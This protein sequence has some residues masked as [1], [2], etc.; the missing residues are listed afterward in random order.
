MLDNARQRDHCDLSSTTTDIDHHRTNRL[1]YGQTD[2]DSGG[3]RLAHQI[4]FPRAN[5]LTG[6]SHRP[7]LDFG[8][9]RRHGDHYFGPNEQFVL[10]HLADKVAYHFLGDF[11]VGD[12][13]VF[14][15]TGDLYFGILA[16]HHLL[17]LCTNRDDFFGCC[18]PGYN[19]WLVENNSFPF[20]E[21]QC[22]GRA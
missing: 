20:D 16:P 4:Y 17:S 6:I 18:V 11:E 9:T 1:F 10:L 15:R 13:T 14:E 8:A 21:D 2:P 19:R 7:F 22:I 12:Y 3:H 5:P